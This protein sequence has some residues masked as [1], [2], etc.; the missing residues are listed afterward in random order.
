MPRRLLSILAIWTLVVGCCFA[1]GETPASKN[2]T[3]AVTP[4]PGTPAVPPRI[5]PDASIAQQMLGF[6]HHARTNMILYTGRFGQSEFA[7][8]HTQLNAIALSLKAGSR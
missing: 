8:T 1:F 3:Q 5:R 2:G 6:E 7:A 4:V